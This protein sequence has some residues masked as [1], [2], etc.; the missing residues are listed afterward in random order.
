MLLALP[1]PVSLLDVLAAL[2][3]ILK[4]MNQAVN[5]R[6]LHVQVQVFI[7]GEFACYLCRLECQ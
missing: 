5:S 6:L 2:I 7:T 3:N 1:D 4:C